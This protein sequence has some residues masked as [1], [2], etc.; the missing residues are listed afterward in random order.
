[1]E[2]KKKLKNE[3][4]NPTDL[5]KGE[6]SKRNLTWEVGKHNML[7]R[8]DMMDMKINKTL[9]SKLYCRYGQYAPQFILKPLKIEYIY[10]EPNITIFHNLLMDFE[11]NH[12]KKKAMPILS[13]AT[14]HNVRTGELSFADYRIS[15]SAWLQPEHDKLVRSLFSKISLATGLDSRSFEPLQVANYGL[16]GQYEPHC[17][18]ATAKTPDTFDNFGGNRLATMLMYMTDVPVGGKTVFTK[19]NPGA[20]I[21]PTKG[22]GAFWFNLK[23]NGKGNPMTEHAAC[24]VVIGAKWVSN[25]WIHERRQ[26]FRHPCTLNKDE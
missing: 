4:I 10:P 15:K 14:V 11:I 9:S 21:T 22:S 1:M 13:R 19:T 12:I 20:S 26:E 16:A 25:V 5:I 3:G 18:H 7:C 23:R 24:P 2:Y 8:G 6:K 17:D